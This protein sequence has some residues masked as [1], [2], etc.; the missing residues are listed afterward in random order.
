MVGV[1]G[2]SKGCQA[3]R[4]KKIACSQELPECLICRNA[5]RKC[6]GY[7]RERLFI[8]HVPS[9]SKTR[10]QRPNP[11]CHKSKQI[12]PYHQCQDETDLIPIGKTQRPVPEY[13]LPL[14]A[15]TLIK[16]P[17]FEVAANQQL[18]FSTIFSPYHSEKRPEAGHWL[19]RLPALPQMSKALEVSALA[20]CTAKLGRRY[21][22]ESLVRESLKVYVDGLRQL[23]KALWDPK[24]MFEDDT[25][26]ACLLLA[27]YEIFE[28][29]A[30]S[31]NG[32]K[33]HYDGCAR[34]VQMRGPSAHASGLGHS[35]FLSFRHIGVRFTSIPKSVADS[36]IY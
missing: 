2:R 36:R 21:N 28:C 5:G 17:R 10:K 33:S 7:Q 30:Q 12:S 15:N 4:K 29:P 13:H 14:S 9:S 18:L 35:I 26:G 19:T 11:T 24:A 3:C 27:M 32:Y 8:I 34:L 16:R 22:D 25:I 1:P 23:Q 20:F 6:P 31:R